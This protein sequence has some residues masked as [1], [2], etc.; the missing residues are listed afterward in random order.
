MRKSVLFSPK[1]SSYVDHANDAVV[2]ASGASPTVN[3]S[4]YQA[5]IQERVW[6]CP[7]HAVDV[8]T[9]WDVATPFCSLHS[10]P[11]FF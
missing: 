8:V 3:G 11:L 4:L 2:P 1:Q 6:T 10:S 5:L 9:P 7:P